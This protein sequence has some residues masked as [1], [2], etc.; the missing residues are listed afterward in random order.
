MPLTV[1]QLKSLI[2]DVPDFPKPGILFR[3]ITPVLLNAE[4]FSSVID[5]LVDRVAS[6]KA[7]HLVAIESRGFVFGAP[8]ADRLGLK[9]VLVR[10][11]GKL[12]SDRI[13]ESYK[14]EYGEAELEIHS[15]SMKAGDRAVVIDDVLATGGTFEAGI[16]LV[17]RLNANPVLCL[18][19]MELAFLEGRK[20][21]SPVPVES[22]I[23]Y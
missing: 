3:D 20:R 5:L 1:S 18:T 11:K 10:K 14:L 16:K 2:R 7:S 12:P 23:V 19:V 9:F 13:S 17:Q 22:L 15:D 21:L 6:Q 8:V 4:A